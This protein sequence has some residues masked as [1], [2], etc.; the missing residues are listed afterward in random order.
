MKI[1]SYIQYLFCQ[2]NNVK[3]IW[4]QFEFLFRK[5]VMLV[6]T[7]GFHSNQ[8]LSDHIILFGVQ[9]DKV[10]NVIVLFVN[11][12]IYRSQL[13]NN[14]PNIALFQAKI[15]K[16]IKIVKYIAIPGAYPGGRT[17]GGPSESLILAP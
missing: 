16:C 7:P 2:C 10:K 1:N 15:K 6:F 11:F 8:S 5:K 14:E 9:G 13:Q 3:T 17:P 12:H 4:K